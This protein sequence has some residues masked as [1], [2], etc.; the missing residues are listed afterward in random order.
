[1]QDRC[2]LGKLPIWVQCPDNRC[3]G[4]PWVCYQRGYSVYS[5]KVPLLTQNTEIPILLMMGN[6]VD[7]DCLG[8]EAKNAT[9]GCKIY[10]CNKDT[11]HKTKFHV[12][13]LNKQIYLYERLLNNVNCN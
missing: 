3:K 10:W 11:L 1:M 2:I 6:T 8:T 5:F 7:Q 13:K 12:A 4:K 9:R